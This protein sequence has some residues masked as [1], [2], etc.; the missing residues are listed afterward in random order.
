M[1]Y[2]K[3]HIFS[4]LC[5]IDIFLSLS[6][7]LLSHSSEIRGWWLMKLSCEIYF[8]ICLTFWIR[9][10]FFNSSTLKLNSSSIGKPLISEEYSFINLNQKQEDFYG[11]F[12]LPVNAINDKWWQLYWHSICSRCFQANLEGSQFKIF[13]SFDFPAKPKPP[14]SKNH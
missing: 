13:S 8:K 14:L 7:T 5:V 2:H 3:I 12:T 11:L 6:I 9:K 10:P 4:H 1:Y